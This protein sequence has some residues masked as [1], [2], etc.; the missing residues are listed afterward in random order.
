MRGIAGH[1]QVLH[2]ALGSHFLGVVGTRSL[3]A[4]NQHVAKDKLELW[5]FLPPDCW[6]N[7]HAPLCFI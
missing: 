3:L 1:V 2:L 6:D 4:P 7:K 5:I